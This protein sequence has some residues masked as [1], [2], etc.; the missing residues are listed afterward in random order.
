MRHTKFTLLSFA[1]ILAFA[2]AA[3]HAQSPQPIV[4]QAASPTSAT[5]ASTAAAVVAKD[6]DSIQAAIKTLQQI[7]AANEEI[8]NKQK[9]TLET[10]GDIEEAAEQLKIFAKRG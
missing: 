3:T 1:L 7:K 4:V 2:S 5:A 9:A 10:I 8:L 6:P